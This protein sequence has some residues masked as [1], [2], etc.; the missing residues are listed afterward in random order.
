[1]AGLIVTKF[2]TDLAVTGAKV[3]A[4]AIDNSKVAAAAGIVYSKLSIADGDL[5]IA[6]T[7]GLQTA[8]DNK[9]DDSEKGAVN[10]V[11]TLNASGKLTSS[12]IP[13]IAITDTFVVA[14]QVAMLALSTAETGDVAVRSDLN[15]SFILAGTDPSVLADWQE[16]LTPTDVVLSVN[17]ATGVVVLDT[18]DVSE[19]STNLYYTAA[20]FNTAFSGKS[21]T[22][23]SEGTNL[24]FT[25]ERAQDAVGSILNDSATIDFTYD[26]VTPGIT[27]IVIDASISA[28]KLATD[29]VETTKIKDANVT[30][31]KIAADAVNDTHI[32][33]GTGANQVS[34]VDL[35]LA[36]AGAYYT[37]DNA[38]AALQQIGATLAALATT[39]NYKENITLVA[40]DITNQYVDLAH[41]A[42]A[43]SIDL[44]PV[45]GPVQQEGVDYTV[46]LTGGAGGKTRISFAGI[47]ATAGAAALIAT[48][49]LVIKYESLE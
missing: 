19:G 37:T 22:D 30:S 14:S 31:A 10:G 3:A 6:K 1:M 18:D 21:T 25:D 26:D 11:A 23:L 41:V 49:V 20:R 4:G 39:S 34:A 13:A 47:L 27:A 17:G 12:Q 38:E 35:P 46:S 9:V 45:G 44:V 42:R 43:A 24:Y 36:D 29:S 48:D 16:L 5:T 40:G 7:S 33:F 28:A 15:K 32:D 2:I 8:L